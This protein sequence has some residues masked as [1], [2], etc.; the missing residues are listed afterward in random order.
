MISDT[1]KAEITAA[2]EARITA[3]QVQIAQRREEIQLLDYDA[4]TATA[5]IKAHMELLHDY[6]KARDDGQKLFGL[7]ADKTGET[8]SSVYERYEIEDDD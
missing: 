4:T 3:L 7:I 8:I 1:T 2:L 6:N 5:I